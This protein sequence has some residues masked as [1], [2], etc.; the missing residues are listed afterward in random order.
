MAGR[1][2]LANRNVV[3]ES[4]P[5]APS[6]PRPRAPSAIVLY[7]SRYGNTK[8][9]AQALARGLGEVE[10][11]RV[12]LESVETCDPGTLASFDLIAVGAPTEWRSASGAVKHFLAELDPSGLRGKRSF[13]FDTRYR[14]ALSGSAAKTI[15]TRLDALGLVP[16]HPPASAIV[17]PTPEPER[18]NLLGPEV[19]P[20]FE[21]L[22]RELGTALVR[23]D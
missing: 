22:G 23:G 11:V 8:I 9:V 7:S 5:S 16:L 13:A 10:G 19:E 2:D 6:E 1:A 4:A 18:E 17:T 15:S 14:S 20:Q 3:G 21:S 12:D